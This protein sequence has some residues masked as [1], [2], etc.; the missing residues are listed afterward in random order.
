MAIGKEIKIYNAFGQLVFESKIQKE[1]R[2]TIDISDFANGIYIVSLA[3]SN[4]VST[5]KLVVNN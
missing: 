5:K 3:D 2:L 4:F 1:N